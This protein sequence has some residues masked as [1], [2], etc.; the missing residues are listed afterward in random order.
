MLIS[1]FLLV[2]CGKNAQTDVVPEPDANDQTYEPSYQ[3]DTGTVDSFE[4]DEISKAAIESNKQAAINQEIYTKA[5][6]D[7]QLEQCQE[8]NDQKLQILCQNNVLFRLAVNSGEESYCN[9]ITTQ[10][11]K[12]YCLESI[13]NQN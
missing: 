5:L 6:E 2:A 10:S 3:D 9:Q 1:S 12:E 4:Q 13:N 7:M 11:T 8:I